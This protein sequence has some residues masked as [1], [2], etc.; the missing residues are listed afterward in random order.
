V[1]GTLLERSAEL[2][3]LERLVASAEDGVG[4]IVALTGP[5]G[6][7][8]STLLEAGVEM[9]RRRDV[10]VLVAR[11]DELESNYSFSV[12]RD[13]FEPRLIKSA[14]AAGLAS[15]PARRA[16]DALDAAGSDLAPAD[17]FAITHGL[18][19]LA[20]DL[21][22]RDPLLIVVDDLQWCDPASARWLIYLAE[23]LDGLRIGLLLSWRTGEPF[24]DGA[25]MARFEASASTG[26]V[27][28]GPLSAAAVGSVLESHLGR[29]PAQALVDALHELTGG[30][31]FL[32]TEIAMALRTDRTTDD[33]AALAQVRELAPRS[34]RRS[35]S[36]RIG[37]LG[38]EAA[39]LASAVAVLGDHAQLVQASTLAGLSL[40]EAARAADSLA[41]IGLFETG[42]PLRFAHPLVRAALYEDIPP[43]A[44]RMCHAAAAEVLARQLAGDELVCAHL[45]RCDPGAYPQ[46]VERLSG[47]ATRAL[48]RG[49]P[50]VAAT[51]LRRALEEPLET[52]E[53]GRLLHGLG[54]AEAL[55][56]APAASE[57]LGAALHL[58]S[59]DADR[60][61][62]AADLAEVLGFRGNWDAA[63]NV[64]ERA[65]A[66]VDDREPAGWGEAGRPPA[67]ERLEYVWA[68]LAAFDPTRIDRF[69]DFV[70]RARESRTSRSPQRAATVAVTLAWR[71]EAPDEV[72][73]LLDQVLA[74]VGPEGLS[75][76]EPMLLMRVCASAFVTDQTARLDRLI[77]DM[78]DASRIEGSVFPLGVAL[79][80][81][82]AA[83]TRAGDLV[84]AASDLRAVFDLV[85]QHELNF[86]VP[87][88]L[89]Y[90]ADALIER[91]EL[92]D[93]AALVGLI[94]LGP[95]L[96][97][98]AIGAVFREVRG[99]LALAELKFE[100]ARC[101]LAEAASTFESMRLQNPNGSC[102]RSALALS[103]AADDRD[104]ALRLVQSELSDARR[105]GWPRPIGV[106]LRAL[107]LVEG[108][109]RGL[110]HL[111]EAV[112][113]LAVSGAR[114]EQARAAVS[115]GSAL[116]R[117]KQRATARPHLLAGLDLAERCGAERLAAKAREELVAAGARPRRAAIT[118][119]ESLTAAERRVAEL[120]AQGMSNREIAQALFVT[121]NTVEGHLKQVFQ[122][123]SISSRKSISDALDRS[124]P[125]RPTKDHGRSVV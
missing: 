28:P 27:S 24:V 84:G 92:S 60:A 75:N 85:Q 119:L 87:P 3:V 25:L 55:M 17:T 100:E 12:V 81:R 49:A 107:G 52:R 56:R 63:L 105:L 23:R 43:V 120:A 69:D 72:S 124:V 9:A 121:I 117:A 113:V 14:G 73:R 18:Y 122:K 65:L 116:R 16:M 13:L 8:K 68:G 39:E 37:R 70:A 32:V 36:L 44:R 2:A 21:C 33:A 109:D 83:R 93:I 42:T 51:Y 47:G 67:F 79:T 98:I 50:E 7:G 114:L 10:R 35:V 58:A 103:L 115:L 38:R 40:E 94:S 41:A 111:N 82:T 53:R 62:I 34:V 99:R 29:R 91:E 66:D 6:I 46:A 57:D 104:E 45:L 11:A 61:A 101:Q 59:S 110:D 71:G 95:E 54:Q 74:D 106:A 123:L 118:G 4:G 26:I 89:W 90:G 15:G 86:S 80:Y 48:A 88:V 30:N 108:G 125:E 96:D 31:P 22:Q 78:L 1:T 77:D 19:W 112:E 102:W 76:A 64:A 97:R 5:A 20:A